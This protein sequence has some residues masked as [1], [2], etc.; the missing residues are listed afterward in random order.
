MG[1]VII[2]AI[3]AC[4]VGWHASKAHGTHRGIP[5]RRRQLREDRRGRLRQGIRLV[6]VASVLGV[7]LLVGWALVSL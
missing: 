5:A 2:V 7:V 4:V 6:T 1:V 3:V